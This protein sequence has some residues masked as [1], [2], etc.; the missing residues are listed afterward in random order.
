MDFLDFPLFYELV[1]SG[2]GKD[3]CDR[4]SFKFTC[5]D[6][7]NY[8]CL[9]FIVFSHHQESNSKIHPDR[10][11]YRF[12]RKIC[13]CNGWVSQN[14][15]LGKFAK[16]GGSFG[17]CTGFTLIL[18][19]FF[20]NH[21]SHGHLTNCVVLYGN[22][23]NLPPSKEKG[24]KSQASNHKLPSIYLLNDFQFEDDGKE[25]KLKN[26]YSDFSHDN[27]FSQESE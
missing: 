26:R 3:I 14:V 21:C 25:Y 24:K 4:V 12:T 18:S 17:M 13:F 7:M 27:N 20:F 8:V 1:S 23:L 5:S 6:M 19:Y 15:C 2:C 22:V 10:G 11:G 9:C 16:I